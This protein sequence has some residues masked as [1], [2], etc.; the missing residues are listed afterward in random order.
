MAKDT[1]TT[2]TL[3]AAEQAVRDLFD[4]QK[5]ALEAHDAESEPL[6]AQM[7]GILEK[8]AVLDAEMAPLADQWRIR[9]DERTAMA[10]A[11]ART[12]RT[13]QSNRG[14]NDNPN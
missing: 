14:T 13:L 8:I 9:K 2:K 3:D 5:A 12:A 7:D 4:A 6:R 1:K 11:L 10:N